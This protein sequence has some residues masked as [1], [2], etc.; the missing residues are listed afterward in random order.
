MGSN[1]TSSAELLKHCSGYKN[2]LNPSQWQIKSYS[3]V[4]PLLKL[5]EIQPLA[6]SQ[7]AF[8][9]KVSSFATEFA[10]TMQ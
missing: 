7:T 6:R 8:K 5:A 9:E 1:T 3:N 10:L 4:H 2:L